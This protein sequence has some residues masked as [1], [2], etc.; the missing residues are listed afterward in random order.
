MDLE[1]PENYICPIT[2]NL[3][4]EP[5]KASDNKIYEKDAILDWLYKNNTS[6]L[7]NEIINPK[8]IFQ[9]ELKLEIKKYTKLNNIKEMEK[10]VPVNYISDK[11]NKKVNLVEGFSNIISFNCFNCNDSLI[12]SLNQ[13]NIKCDCNNIYYH[14]ICVKCKKIYIELS[15]FTFR[16]VCNDCGKDNKICEQC[17]IC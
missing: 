5:V 7:T 9:E 14:N 11:K 16:F 17:I 3:M 15:E 10:Y 8:I 12:L 2:L 6:P 1:I 13:S 4:I